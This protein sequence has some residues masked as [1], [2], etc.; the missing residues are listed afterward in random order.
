M[1][2]NTR[3][4]IWCRAPWST[5]WKLRKQEN[6]ARI[7]WACL[8]RNSVTHHILLIVISCWVIYE[9]RQWMFWWL[10]TVKFEKQNVYCS[11][12]AIIISFCEAFQLQNIIRCQLQPSKHAVCSRPLKQ[13]YCNFENT[14]RV[15][16]FVT[17][18]EI[19]HIFSD[20]MKWKHW[21]QQST[22]EQTTIKIALALYDVIL[23]SL[24]SICSG[25]RSI[26][27]SPCYRLLCR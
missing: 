24:L 23:W 15:L 14:K 4:N 2:K 3:G 10:P 18:N 21:A 7:W 27:C 1:I 11:N 8:I 12:K 25:F 13:A 9:R 5:W 17:L 20:P 26:C 16:N 22:T 6:I 19:R